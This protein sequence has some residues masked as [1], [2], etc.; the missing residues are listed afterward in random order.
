MVRN[1]LIG[2]W[3][4]VATLGSA[5][6]ALYLDGL[7]KAQTEAGHSEAVEMTRTKELNIPKVEH[8]AITGYLVVKLAIMAAAG[9]AEHGRPPVEPFVA[10]EAL[11]YLYSDAS[12]SFETPTKYEISRFTRAVVDNVNKRVGSKAVID[13]AVE[14]FSFVPV[15]ELKT[16][17]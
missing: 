1:L 17:K 8:G 6:G 5:F 10:D 16:R 3:A 12:A 14:E 13:V 9:G 7:K 15:S 4:V 11:R 2:I